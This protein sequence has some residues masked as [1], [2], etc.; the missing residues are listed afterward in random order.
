MRIGFITLIV[1]LLLFSNCQ[2]R[3]DIL[4]KGQEQ[5]ITDTLKA[6]ATGFLK[7]WEPPFYPER[8]LQLFTQ[9]EDFCLI[10][11]GLLIENYSEWAEGVPNYMADDNYF[12][13][14][15]KH[16]IKEIRTVVL[17]RDAGVVTIIYVWDSVTKEGV[18]RK[19][20]GA[21]TLTCRREDHGW[22]I[23]HYHGSHDEDRIVE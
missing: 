22:R 16:E 1:S 17:S 19:T 2:S 3:K 20:N 21:I 14:S 8:A 7:S 6:I 9:T 4:T 11:D 10:I 23:I 12:F 5:E 15:Y 13:S 18:H